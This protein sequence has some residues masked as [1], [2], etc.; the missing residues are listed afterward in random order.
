M[1]TMLINTRFFW[2]RK[3][4]DNRK[5]KCKGQMVIKSVVNDINPPFT[6]DAVR[7]CPTVY[8]G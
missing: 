2:F 6:P 7:L 5:V 3:K 1:E 4:E 8:T